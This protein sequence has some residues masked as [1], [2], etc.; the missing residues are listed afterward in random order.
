[1]IQHTVS[2]FKDGRIV[3]FYLMHENTIGLQ[4]QGTKNYG[5]FQGSGIVEG[6]S[7]QPVSIQQEDGKLLLFAVGKSNAIFYKI[8]KNVNSAK[9]V[10]DSGTWTSL[11]GWGLKPTAALNKD[12]SA[13]IFI[14]GSDNRIYSKWQTSPNSQNWSSD[15]L[16]IGDDHWVRDIAVAKNKDGRL[17]VFG[18]QEKHNYIV[19]KAQKTPDKNGGWG[20]WKRL[21][22]NVIEIE[23]ITD[24]RGIIHLF[25][26]TKD[27]ILHHNWQKQPNC[28]CWNGWEPRGA[29]AWITDI[30]AIATPD[31]NWV[32]VG[33]S[34]DNQVVYVPSWNYKLQLLGLGG[35]SQYYDDFD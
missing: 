15:Y 4:W 33:A 24:S 27:N 18:I 19:H 23:A 8:E 13:Q 5:I 14:I 7:V 32:V 10:K 6:W 30:S 29:N 35:S 9:W 17:E 31:G 28:D 1:V 20:D 11:G 3:V 12:G 26:V 22:N 34:G 2:N 21:G 25:A 16:G